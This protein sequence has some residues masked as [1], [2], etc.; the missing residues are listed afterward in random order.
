MHTI[1]SFEVATRGIAKRWGLLSALVML[2]LLVL[3]RILYVGYGLAEL[4]AEFGGSAGT[5]A[6]HAAGVL[7][8]VQFALALAALP[9]LFRHQPWGWVLAVVGRT[10]ALLAGVVALFDDG[11]RFVFSAAAAYA[12]LQGCKIGILL[13]GRGEYR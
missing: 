1:R 13:H 10:V 6:F 11:T 2:G 9:G 8:C 12:A 7:Y 4:G 5:T 3:S